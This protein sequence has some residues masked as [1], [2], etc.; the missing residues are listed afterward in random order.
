[1][2]EKISIIVAIYNSEKYLK[3]C[4][5]SLVKQTYTNIEIVLVND[6]STDD[7]AFICKGFCDEYE[8]IKYIEV[9][10]GGCVRARKLGI[11]NATGNIVSFMD[12]DDWIEFNAIESMYQQL[13]KND[14]DIVVAGYYENVCDN[15]RVIMNS[16]S[17]GVYRGIALEQKIYSQMLCKENYF[18]FGIVPFLVNKLYRREV[19]E[20]Y[21]LETNDMIE[22]GEDV[23]RVYPAILNSNCV[24]ILDEAYYHYRIHGKS[25]AHSYRD[26]LKEYQNIQLQQTYLEGVFK[27]HPM[28]DSLFYQLERYIK[29]HQMVRCL[30]L[31]NELSQ[32][33]NCF[34]FQEMEKGS[35]IIIYGAGAFGVATHQFFIS[36]K[37]YNVIGWC[38]RDYIKYQ[39][40]DYDVEDTKTVL[41]REF[42][43]IVIAIMNETTVENIKAY[44]ARQNVAGKRVIWLNVA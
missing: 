40:L 22:V 44:L 6:G 39:S 1:M 19:I 18:S 29:H 38:D 43:Y 12:S 37:E 3:Q 26:D 23:V 41:N 24:C 17:S 30:P 36:S 21:I 27:K 9:E 2:T 4:I 5:E 11:Q 33:G 16:I 14:A 8:N 10:N 35:N 28:K 13:C 20:K 42:D 7:S 31:F 34:P 25:M 15:E 32:K